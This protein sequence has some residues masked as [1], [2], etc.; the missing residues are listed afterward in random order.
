ML[1]KCSS[2]VCIESDHFKTIKHSAAEFANFPMS[3]CFPLA[4]QYPMFG[5][6][7]ALT[8][9]PSLGRL[10]CNSFSDQTLMEMLIDGLDEKSKQKYRDNKGTYL[11]VCEWSSVTCDEFKRVIK[12]KKR[13]TPLDHFS[14]AM[15][16]PKCGGSTYNGRS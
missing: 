5:I 14:F 6:A 16:R 13:M 9:D 8:V 12:S 4:L 10:D 15:F 1:G 7:S 3:S 2:R 11:D